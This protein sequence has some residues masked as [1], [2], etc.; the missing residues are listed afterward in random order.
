MSNIQNTNFPTREDLNKEFTKEVFG[1][2]DFD[3]EV[4][5][6]TIEKQATYIWIRIYLKNEQ[7]IEIGSK[8]NMKYLPTGETLETTFGAFNK[9]NLN[10]DFDDEVIGYESEDDKTCLCLMINLEWVNNPNNNIRFIRS[11]FKDGRFFD[12]NNLLLREDE[13][14]FILDG[15]GELDYY[16]M[17]L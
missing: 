12:S 14:S 1:G 7:D 8:I 13:V 4:N 2:D 5:T 10:K 3:R 6:T 17:Q 16:S 15:Y 9:K 11:L